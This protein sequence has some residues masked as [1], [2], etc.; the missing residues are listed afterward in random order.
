MARK[1][2]ENSIFMVI[3]RFQQDKKLYKKRVTQ[4]EGTLPTA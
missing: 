4:N 2:S 3:L 1:I